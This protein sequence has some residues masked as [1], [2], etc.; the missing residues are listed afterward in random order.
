MIDTV[1]DLD[2]VLYEICNE[3][4]NTPQAMAWMDYLCQ[5]VREY[6]ASKPRQHM[7]GIT[8]EGGDQ[9]PEMLFATSADW[10]S[11]ASSRGFEY[12]YNPPPASG[13][14]VIFNDTD[15]LWGHGCEVSWIWKSFTRGMNVLLMDPWEPIPGDLDWWQDG[16]QSRNQRY[17]Y[18]WDD[19]RRNLGYTRK[20]ALSFDMN[21]LIP[22]TGFCTSTYCLANRNQQYICFFPAGGTEGVDLTGLDGE[23]KVAWL[24]PATGITSA[25]EPLPVKSG[26]PHEVFQRAALT[27]AV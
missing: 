4:P 8:A 24:N 16:D 9:I 23:F 13:E 15:H 17:Y 11:P 7:I 5:Y 6:E 19:M 14:K 1:N 18:A 22:D 3:V 25:G 2:N 27:R 20:I 12:R 21:A 10:I 26:S